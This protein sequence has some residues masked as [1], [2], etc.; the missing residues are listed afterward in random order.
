M[1]G[2]CRA[3]SPVAP[4][5]RR[6]RCFVPASVVHWIELTGPVSSIRAP[7]NVRSQWTDLL[8]TIV[9]HLSGPR[10]RQ[11]RQAAIEPSRRQPS[12][13]SR[14]YHNPGV[15]TQREAVAAQQCDLPFRLQHRTSGSISVEAPLSN[16][17]GDDSSFFKGTKILSPVNHHRRQ[18]VVATLRL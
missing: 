14:Q 9:H 6:N 10:S 1:I 12:P 7:A 2:S 15:A 5:Q 18:R 3:T 8:T 17:V 4:S 11:A 13:S 16:T